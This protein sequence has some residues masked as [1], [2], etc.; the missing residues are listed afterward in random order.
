MAEFHLIRDLHDPRWE[1]SWLYLRPK[2]DAS[3]LYRYMSYVIDSAF[4]RAHRVV[5]KENRLSFRL[6]WLRARFPNAKIVHIYRDATSQWRSNIRRSQETRE[7]EDVGQDSVDYDGFNVATYCEQLKSVFPE[8]DAEKFSNGF[9]RFRAL[10]ERS[11]LEGQKYSDVSIA[12]H[13]LTHNFEST[14]SNVWKVIGAPPID[15]A[16]LKRYVVPPEQQADLIRRRSLI[17]KDLDPLLTRESNARGDD[18][19]RAVDDLIRSEMENGLSV[20]QPEGDR[21]HFLN[22]TGTL[23]L[24]LC[25]GSNSVAEIVRVVQAAFA[26]A[27]PPELEVRKLLQQAAD[28][29]IVSWTRDSG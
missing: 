25:D 8:L 5:F 10:W 29:G 13:D 1:K 2:D 26:L 18:Y 15:I 4:E 11:F 24:E 3:D 7:C 20:Y 6:G 14:W 22:H 27:E 16:S 28:V 9:E 23:I 21:V 17:V 19:P 12:Y